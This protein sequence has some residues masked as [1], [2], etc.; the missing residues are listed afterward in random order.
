MNKL[1]YSIF[2]LNELEQLSRRRQWPNQLNPTIK[3]LATLIYIIFVTSVGRFN[4]E[5]AILFGIYPVLMIAIADIPIKAFVSKLIIPAFISISLGIV[6]PFFDREPVLFISGFGI[7]GGLISMTTLFVKAL[8]TIS[9]TLLLVSTTS[10]DALGIGMTTLKIPKKLVL[11][12]LLMYRYIGVLLSEVNR[13]MEAYQLRAS[14]SKGIHISTWG[15]LVGQI[16]IRSYKRSEDI[17][18]A[19]Q[20]RGYYTGERE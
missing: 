3:I 8:L 14:R 12:L 6:N 16:I 13:T 11:L 9:A 20:L 1:V 19:M 5:K 18:Q 10:I 4:L 17:H 2:N 15:S 7:S